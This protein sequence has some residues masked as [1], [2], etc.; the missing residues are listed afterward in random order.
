MR[1][2]IRWLVGAASLTMIAAT[3]G[4]TS[5]ASASGPMQRYIVRVRAGANYASVR[6]A[7][8]RQGAS[9]V[10]DLKQVGAF[11][12]KARSGLSPALAATAGVQGLA[13]DHIETVA[14]P[15]GA[16]TSD[17]GPAVQTMR[18]M[19]PGAAGGGTFVPDP[20]VRRYRSLVWDYGR[21]QAPR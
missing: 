1:K 17:G 14:P 8:A 16:R 3:L 21:I 10:M 20:I 4:S 13:L 19:L 15:E 2:S 9:V 6:S 11:V 18:R 12:V 5:V 7:V